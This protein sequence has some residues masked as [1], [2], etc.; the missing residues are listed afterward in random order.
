MT[1]AKTVNIQTVVCITCTSKGRRRG[2]GSANA[3]PSH[4]CPFYKERKH[5]QM[6]AA[7]FIPLWPSLGYG[8][9][10]VSR[11]AK[12]ASASLLHLLWEVDKDKALRWLL[13]L[14]GNRVCHCGPLKKK[15]PLVTHQDHMVLDTVPLPTLATVLQR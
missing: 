3:L 1:A 2:S 9:T 15:K 14:P 12:K 11:E 8:A 5:S 4:T 13:G 6:P 7:D 10:L